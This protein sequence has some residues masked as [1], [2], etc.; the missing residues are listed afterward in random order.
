VFQGVAPSR[1]GLARRAGPRCERL[2][3]KPV[4]GTTI[5]FWSQ[6]RCCCGPNF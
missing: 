5:A 4:K 1:T 6:S 2:C 3:C